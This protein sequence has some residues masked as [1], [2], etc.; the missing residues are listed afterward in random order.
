MHWLLLGAFCLARVLTLIFGTSFA[1]LSQP[2]GFSLRKWA[3]PCLASPG[4]D[5]NVPLN[6]AWF[7]LGLVSVQFI[8]TFSVLCL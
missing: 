6:K 4:L 2:P 1:S 8:S 5:W 3:F 7:S